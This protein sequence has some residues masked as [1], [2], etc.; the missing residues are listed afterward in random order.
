MYDSEDAAWVRIATPFSNSELHEFCRDLERVFRINPLLEFIEWRQI[1]TNNYHLHLKN[2][3]NNQQIKTIISVE[4]I[5]DG[6]KINYQSGI[7]TSTILKIEAEALTIIDDYSG[8]SETE[9]QQNLAQ[10][11]KS[12]IP[13]GNAI[14]KYLQNWQRWKWFPLYRWYMRRVWQ[15]MK[16]SGRRIAYMLIVISCFEL[17]A[18]SVFLIV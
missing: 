5:A 8:T 16:P 17:L 9:R 12:L 2:L 13:W 4:E 11:D 3:S 1:D 6:F 18:I 10:V 14:Y 7:K 15:T